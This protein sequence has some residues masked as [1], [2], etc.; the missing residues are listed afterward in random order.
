MTIISL[1][2][3]LIKIKISVKIVGTLIKIIEKGI[4]MEKILSTDKTR[5]KLVT[6]IIF[7][8]VISH[9]FPFDI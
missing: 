6:I 7:S 9:D 2:G 5:K 3:T 4:L 8:D 1:T